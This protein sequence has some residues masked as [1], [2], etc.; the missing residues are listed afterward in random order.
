MPALYVSGKFLVIPSQYSHALISSM[1]NA[2]YVAKHYGIWNLT[3][4]VDATFKQ[5]FLD[6]LI[7]P[8]Q[9]NLVAKIGSPSQSGRTAS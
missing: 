8:K 3:I 6:A 2:T 4:T 9:K 5:Y 1:G 7:Y